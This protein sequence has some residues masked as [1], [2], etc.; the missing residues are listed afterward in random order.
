MPPEGNQDENEEP[1]PSASSPELDVVNPPET[2][3]GEA[4]SSPAAGEPADLLSVVRDVVSKGAKDAG[5]A[6]PAAG[7]EKTEATE[8]KVEGE[9]DDENYSDVPF[10]KHPRFQE[11]LA[12]NRE[13]KGDA[14]RYQNVQT[15]MQQ[16]SLGAEEVAEG[17]IVMGLA[18]TNPQEAW[19]RI[20]PF[21]QALL[22]AA[23]EVLPQDL[24]ARVAA[25]ELS[26]ESA[27]EMSRLRANV[28]SNEAQ[29]AQQQQQ[30]ETETE[31]R[32][33][34][35]LR[36]AAT[37]WQED[38][39]AKDPRFSEKL[40]PLLRE[41]AFLQH[42]A[43]EG[44]PNTPEGVRDQL[45]RAYAAVNKSFVPVV[46][47]VTP[48]SAAPPLRSGQ[49]GGSTRPEPKSVLDIVRNGG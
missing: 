29:R 19:R 16:H 46:P 41:V 15:F 2:A 9:K 26:N 14:E 18:K 38:R 1:N 23:G 36:G 12:K 8:E 32:R 4:G 35:A 49:V 42:V 34:E 40:T 39:T 37:S 47:P 24:Q 27:F 48:R 28:Q 44:V 45:S 21:L 7:E 22:P 5:A 20:Q 43:G 30:R 33:V 6:S 11:L 17:L 31:T 10:N 25:G 13:Y 3:E